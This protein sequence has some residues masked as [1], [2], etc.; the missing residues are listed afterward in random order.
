VII[1]VLLCAAFSALFQPLSAQLF[2]P[3]LAPADT[4]GVGFHAIGLLTR[5]SPA[6]GGEAMRELYL[7]QPMVMI[8]D[9][10][11]H[12]SGHMM[13]NFEAWTL[14]DGELNAGTWGEGFVDR[15]HPHTFL[16][17]L[18]F[19]AHIRSGLFGASV[20]GGRGFVPFGSD[21]PM[22]RP[23]VKYP[24]NHHLAQILE[25]WLAVGTLRV[26]RVALEGAAFNGDEP[27]GPRSTGRRSRFGDSYAARATLWPWDALELSAS[28]AWVE[29]PENPD[30]GGLDHRKWHASARLDA[31]PRR[32][33]LYALYE[34]ARTDEYDEDAPA[35]TFEST[36]LEAGVGLGDTRLALRWERTTRPEEERLE[37]PFRSARPHEDATLMGVTRWSGLTLHAGRTGAVGDVTVAP[38]L[39]IGRVRVEEIS[40]GL[41]D[42]TA[43]YGDDEQ[44]SVSAGVR[45]TAGVR[46][47]RVGRYGEALRGGVLGTMGSP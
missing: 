30:G 32:V 21:D 3:A 27:D 12:F 14:K 9:P 18:V 8:H 15:R 36:L 20:A 5:V 26:G 37:D 1:A 11:P 44:W 28:R 42:P 35:F 40:G 6:V 10:R 19:S 41:F 25:R 43:F 13:L 39:E 47:Q 7:T 31:A 38:F 29:S 34:W 22:A 2:V 4:G 23:F 24:F 33:P 46:P 17:E 16:H 45:V